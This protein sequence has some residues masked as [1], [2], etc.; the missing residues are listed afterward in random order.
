MA[1]EYYKSCD[2]YDPNLDKCG[3][4]S[5]FPCERYYEFSGAFRPVG[6]GKENSV[7]KAIIM[8]HGIGDKN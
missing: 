6:E 3:E 2:D 8:N 7:L 5:G 1:C 4:G